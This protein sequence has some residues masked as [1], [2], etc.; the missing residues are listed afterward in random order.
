MYP[1]L[2]PTTPLVQEA[3]W[4]ALAEEYLAAGQ[5][6][7]WFEP[8][9]AAAVAAGRQLPW[10]E[11]TGH[12]WLESWLEQPVHTPPGRRAL[13]VGCGVGEDVPPLLA[14]GYD[15][16]AL[17][18]APTALAW[19]RQRAARRGDGSDSA[20]D[21]HAGDV[22]APGAA[23]TGAFDLVVEIHTVPWLPGVVRDAAMTAIAGTVAPGGVALVITELATSDTERSALA[24]PPWPQAPSEL[25]AYRAG[26]LVRLA[27]EHPPAG[28]RATM[29]VRITWQRPYRS[30][31][32]AT[33][34]S[35]LPVVG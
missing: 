16:T 13:L 33:V 35:G 4:R 11:A 6:C 22:L 27:L 17:D 31:P 29:E 3:V 12:P 23:L 26:G 8:A 30:D 20:V 18:I 25:A 14:R 28:D 9:Y 19:A 7:G 24:G 34:G 10:Q 1:T 5:P 2:A 15:V 32:G 21:W